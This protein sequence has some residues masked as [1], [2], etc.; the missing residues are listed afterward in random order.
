MKK[1]LKFSKILPL[2]MVTILLSSN[3]LKSNWLFRPEHKYLFKADQEYFDRL[4]LITH[5]IKSNVFA[6]VAAMAATYGTY[7]AYQWLK[8]KAENRSDDP[9]VQAESVAAQELVQEAETKKA[10]ATYKELLEIQELLKTKAQ[11]G[12]T[13]ISFV[14]SP[15][16][17]QDKMAKAEAIRKSRLASRRR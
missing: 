14:A 1:I 9:K 8:N 11:T 2:I 13:R 7:K 15:S 12:G 10:Y 17:T 6:T 5:T 4:D 16:L 3:N